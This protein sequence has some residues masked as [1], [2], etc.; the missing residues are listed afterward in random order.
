MKVDFVARDAA[1]SSGGTAIAFCF[2]GGDVLVDQPDLAG[3]EP[4]RLTDLMKRNGFTGETGKHLDVCGLADLR[5]D[6]LIIV[7]LGARDALGALA[8]EDAAGRAWAAM[9]RRAAGVVEIWAGGLSPE[10][11]AHAAL[12]F[13][14]ASYVFDKYKL[15]KNV[16]S[17]TVLRVIT[18]DPDAAAVRFGPLAAL[19]EGIALA[20]DLTN[21]P[22]N[23]LFPD[24]FAERVKALEAD[25]LAI[26]ILGESDMAELGMGA[27]LGVGQGSR[28]ESRLVICEWRGSPQKDAPPLVLVGK[29]V[30]FDAGGLSIKTNSGMRHMKCDMGGAAAV[31]GTMLTLAGRKARANVV[32]VIGLVENMPDGNAQRPGDVVTSMS[33]QTI[34]IVNTDAE[35]RLVLAD[36]LWYAQR[37]FAPRAMIDLATLTGNVS[38]ALGDDY[39]AL[40]GNDDAVAQQVLDSAEAE[41]ELMWRLPLVAAYDKL[42]DTPV[43]DMKNVAGENFEAGA[44]TAALFLQRFVNKVPW[45]HLD[46]DSVVWRTREDRPTLPKGAT[47]YGVRCLNRLVADHFE[48]R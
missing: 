18:R 47:G 45:V 17:P 22:G 35:G 48:H 6:R 12:G 24:S 16:D 5:A 8:V 23:M 30:T 14:L 2:E 32:G 21:E 25:G 28:R 15:V 7:G 10:Q 36:V 1:H 29:G 46:I 41:G 37:Q 13:R 27:L 34:E 40:M 19:A 43:A 26:S 4:A 9:S 31:I 3:V 33:G 38:Y 20:R 39:A 11:A 44:I 42:H